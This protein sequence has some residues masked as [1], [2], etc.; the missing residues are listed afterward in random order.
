MF[1]EWHHARSAAYCG[2]RDKQCKIS[3]E[4]H[5]HGEIRVLTT[6]EQILLYRLLLCGEKVQ[7]E[8]LIY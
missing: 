3:S 7:E 8:S 5:L 6:V 4:D 1:L 2:L